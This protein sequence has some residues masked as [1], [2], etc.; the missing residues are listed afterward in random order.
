MSDKKSKPQQ[1][2]KNVKQKKSE[3]QRAHYLKPV[4]QILDRIKWDNILNKELDEFIIG[5]L[6][7]F[8]GIMETTIQ[9]YE[10]G[11]LIPFHRIYYLKLHGNVCIVV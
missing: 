1:E 11:A 4:D 9:E 3:E 5:Y 7:R 8:L 2:K 6:D 10:E